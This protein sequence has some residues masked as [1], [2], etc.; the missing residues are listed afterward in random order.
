MNVLGLTP[1]AW[2]VTV[3]SLLC[4]S[5]FYSVGMALGRNTGSGPTHRHTPWGISLILAVPFGSA[6]LPLALGRAVRR[7]VAARRGPPSVV[8]PRGAWAQ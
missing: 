8:S 5:V 7:G 2:P 4:L 3:S 6:D 1:R